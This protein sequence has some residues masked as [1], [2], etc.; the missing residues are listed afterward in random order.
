MRHA[1][2]FAILFCSAAPARSADTPPVLRSAKSGPW[3]QASTWEGNRVPDA[4]ARVLIRKGHHVLYDVA[5][6]KV[7]RGINVAGTL[8]F[9][10]DRDT[11][12]EVGLL[13]IQPGDEYSEEGFDCE[14]HLM[15]AEPGHE[16]PAL[17]I[18]TPDRPVDAKHTALIRLHH[19]AGTNPESCPAIVCCGG[20]MDLHGTAEPH[21]GQARRHREAR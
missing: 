4:G 17:E 19:V 11:R 16:R 3:S 8:R 12:L 14:G 5:S 21:L 13:K 20:R 2:L 10:T 15:T 7:I 18:G 9:A 6:E 1:A